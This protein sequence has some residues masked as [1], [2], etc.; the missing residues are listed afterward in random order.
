MSAEGGEIVKVKNKIKENK[1]SNM[2]ISNG[3]N[4]DLRGS[5]SRGQ[6]SSYSEE[7]GG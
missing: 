4:S 3:T 5:G 1:K 2:Y 6:E 7:A